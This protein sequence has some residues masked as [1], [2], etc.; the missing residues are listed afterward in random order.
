MKIALKLPGK[1]VKE[2]CARLLENLKQWPQAAELYDKAECWESAA[3]AYI[4]TKNWYSTIDDKRVSIRLFYSLGFDWAKF[5]NMSIHRRFIR[6]TDVHVKVKVVSKK[7]V[8][9]I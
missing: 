2:E 3:I 7:L 9:P 5:F 4:K 8:R 1:E 6:C